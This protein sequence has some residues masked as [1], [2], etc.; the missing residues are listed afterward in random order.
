[1]T[2]LP[3]G[4]EA[5]IPT[6][7]SVPIGRGIVGDVALTGITAVIGDV[8]KDPRFNIDI[9]NINK[10]KNWLVMHRFPGFSIYVESTKLK[11]SY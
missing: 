2:V 11:H 6:G 5:E 8:Y 1:M 7:I 4:L 9:D 3:Q 10:H